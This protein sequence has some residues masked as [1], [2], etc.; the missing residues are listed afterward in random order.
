MSVTVTGA[1][2]DITLG[3]LADRMFTALGG[4]EQPEDDHEAG[5]LDLF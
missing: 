1:V 5:D 2:G 3:A 4:E